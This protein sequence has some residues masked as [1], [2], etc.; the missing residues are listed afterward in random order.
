MVAQVSGSVVQ[1][2]PLHLT[3]AAVAKYVWKMKGDLQ[4]DYG[5]LDPDRPAPVVDIQQP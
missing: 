1:A 5:I 2:L 4:F 3:L